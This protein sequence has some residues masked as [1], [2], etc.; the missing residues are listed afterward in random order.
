MRGFITG[1]VGGSALAAVG[2]RDGALPVLQPVEPPALIVA[3]VAPR[4]LEA[5]LAVGLARHPAPAVN[6]DARVLSNPTE[7][8]REGLVRDLLG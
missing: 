2:P 4:L 7:V 5:A 3:P 8:G 6:P 1:T